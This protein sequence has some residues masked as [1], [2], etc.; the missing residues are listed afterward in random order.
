MR[1]LASGLATS[2]GTSTASGSLGLGP[3]GPCQAIRGTVSLTSRPGV[4]NPP[5]RTIIVALNGL[6]CSPVAG[7]MSLSGRF[8]TVSPAGAVQ[9]GPS[10]S[11][12]GR[13]HG[14]SSGRLVL[15]LAGSM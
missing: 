13:A 1:I 12:R 8:Q 14:V 6:L 3:A 5:L 4:T 10:G 15:I 11:F 9:A 7:V 2:L